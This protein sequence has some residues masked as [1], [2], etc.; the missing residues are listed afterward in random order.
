[1]A[2]QRKWR[3]PITSGTYGSWRAMLGRCLD[4]GNVAYQYYGGRGIT[5]CDEWISNYDRFYDDMGERPPGLT[6]DRKDCELGYSI[7]NCQWADKKSQMNNRRTTIMVTHREV[8]MTLSQWAEHLGV[9]YYTLW[10]RLRA[11]A[12][13]PEKA[14]TANSLDPVQSHGNSGYSRGCRCDLCRQA[15]REYHVDYKNRKLNE[16]RP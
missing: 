2:T 12:M 5:V 16:P 1:M 9:P 10:N 6:L 13:S 11:H 4:P 7:E 8:T 14:L 15:R 3:S